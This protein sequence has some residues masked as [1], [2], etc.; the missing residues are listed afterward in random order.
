MSKK[1]SRIK[2]LYTPNI[3]EPKGHYSQAVQY[4]DTIY[5]S[6]QLPVNPFTGEP[7]QGDI[8]EQTL[9]VLE[10]IETILKNA[11]SDKK[12][13]LKTTVYI[14]DMSNWG[15]VNEVYRMFFGKHKP[16]RAVVPTRELHYG[17]FIEIE[18][19]AAI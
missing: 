14:S 8:E 12:K 11:G 18:A 15:R 9:Q 4:N 13:I 2:E 16:A 6:G 7:I 10:N 5:V 1:D 3:P 19:V 17:V